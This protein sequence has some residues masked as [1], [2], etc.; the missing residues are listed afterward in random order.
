LKDLEK[1]CK[2]KEAEWAT[3]CKIRAEEILALADTI[4]IL[5]DD[6]ALDLFKN[7][8]SLATTSTSMGF[9]QK[10]SSSS[11]AL[12]AHDLVA[13][14]AKSDGVH[15]NQLA[16]IQ[17]SLK[18]KSVD[19]SKVIAQIDNMS[20]IM[21]SEQK[22][23][24]AQKDFCDKDMAKS[25]QQKSDT[26]E[27]IA[28]SEAS[29]EEMMAASA[30]LAAE[31][32]QLNKDVKA[33]DKAVAD[34]TQQR[35]EEH[36]EFLQYSTESNA[37]VQLI[38]KA[39]N[40]L[41]QFYRPNLHKA[42][43]TRG[44]LT[45]EERLLVASGADDM[46][47]STVAPQ[48]IEGTTQT[49]YVQIKDD[50]APPPPPAT[51]DAYQKKDGKSNGVIALMEMLAKELTDDMTAA[52]HEEETSQ[53]DYERL[54]AD[55]QASRSQNVESITS[56][57]AAKS[58]LDVNTENTKQQKTSQTTELAN[59]N[60]YIAQL[61]AN[62]DFLIDNYALRKA[63]RENESESLKNAKSVLSGANFN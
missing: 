44:P 43:P 46:V 11:V 10:Q 60:G 29:I 8:L 36:A 5:N 33:L 58:D 4:K 63:A 48:M 31:I 6:D 1:N 16:L 45:E 41:F 54:M 50:A 26:E 42:A 30:A 21:V 12:R 19:F 35:K 47:V 59:I 28:S 14:A 40:R 52:K 24:D 34:A 3:R 38:E 17:F 51:W 56:K 15:K 20:A 27:S 53:K 22:D 62:C 7:T 49:L 61:H 57:E 18:A 13:A 2:T 25:E 23:D 55:S 32:E 39:K 9:L 37:A